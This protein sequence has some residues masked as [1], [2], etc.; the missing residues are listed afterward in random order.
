MASAIIT[1]RAHP[2][3][4]DC[5]D[6]RVPLCSSAVWRGPAYDLRSAGTSQGKCSQ[7]S[8]LVLRVWVE[9]APGNWLVGWYG[10]VIHEFHSNVP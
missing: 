9:A 6:L 2:E 4:G 1:G 3:A 5:K 8:S 10:V 7:I